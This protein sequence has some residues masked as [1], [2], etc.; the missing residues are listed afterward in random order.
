MR[1]V[2][3]G[4]GLSMALSGLMIV[5]MSLA[6]RSKVDFISKWLAGNVWGL[7]WAFVLAIF[8]C[9]VILVPY[10]LYKSN[11]LNI[12]KLSRDV[13]IGVGMSIEK[14]RFKLLMASVALSSFAV[15]VTGNISFIGLM[16]PHI[17]KALVGHRNQMFI[18][19]AILMGGWLLLLADT[20]GQHLLQSGNIPA[21]IVVSVIGAPYFI[22]LLLKK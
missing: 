13:S 4:V 19:I 2:L 5:I 10:I 8:P 21:G 20:I 3:L 1:L 11:T 9:I 16:A 17:A 22:Y 18:P 15:S 14:E 7:D 12:I 6:D